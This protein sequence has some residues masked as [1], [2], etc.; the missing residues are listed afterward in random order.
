MPT[1]SD[2]DPLEE[3]RA[4]GLR[5]ARELVAHLERMGARMTVLPVQ[6]EDGTAHLVAIGPAAFIAGPEGREMI[7]LAA[8]R[9]PEPS[10]A[11][12]GGQP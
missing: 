12:N 10:K 8:S 5:L 1:L 7:A 4:E 11:K 6:A 3:E 2:H 9:E